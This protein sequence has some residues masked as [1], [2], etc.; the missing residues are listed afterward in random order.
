MQSLRA[1]LRKIPIA[2]YLYHR[3][4]E[5]LLLRAP[6]SATPYGF[7]MAGNAAMRE[8]RFEPEEVELVRALLAERDVVVDVGA[9]IGLY[10]CL[11][12]SLGR[13][14][15]VVEPHPGNLRLLRANLAANGWDDTEVVPKGLAQSPGAAP[16]F[17]TSTGASLV[18]GWAQLPRGTLQRET[19]ELTTLDDLL[20]GRFLGERLLVKADIEGAEYSMLRGATRTLERAP[21]PAWLVEICLT[22]NFPGGVN[23]DYVATF[24]AFFSRGYTAR[25][26]NA[27]ARPVARADVE[28]W[29]RE[30]RAE[31]CTHNYLFVR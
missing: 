3:L 12:R 28:R 5:A 23:P 9:N 7:R 2:A 4:R 14:A 11:A 26:A 24:D 27:A 31:S 13:R 18:P 6:M 21:A 15:L 17:G 20:E 22:E 10:T 16:L 25:T 1:R 8:G 29:A 30:G 19:I